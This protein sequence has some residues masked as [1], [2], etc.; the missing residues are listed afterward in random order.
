MPRRA[1]IVIPGL[2]HHVTQ[3]GNRR[4]QTF[5]SNSD[6]RLYLDLA[7]ESLDRFDVRCWAYCLMPNHVHWVLE[8]SRP[9]ALARAMA[10]LH[11]RYTAKVNQREEWT[12]YL[13]QGRFGSCAMDEAHALA[14]IRYIELNPV[15]ASPCARAQDWPWSSATAHLSGR[16]APPLSRIAFL[17]RIEDWDRYLSEPLD[18]SLEARLGYFTGTGYPMG[19][20]A[21]LQALETKMARPLRPRKQGRPRHAESA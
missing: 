11:Q 5:F 15:A 2:P 14:A 13:W 3:R 1:R 17:E 7:A 19:D 8:P 9:D 10:R 18:A 4:Q 12:G 6:Y 20:D 21:W 16:L